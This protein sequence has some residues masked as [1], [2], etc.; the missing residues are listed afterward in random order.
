MK[1]RRCFPIP[2][3]RLPGSLSV[4]YRR[5]GQP[6]RHG[7][8]DKQGHPIGFLTFMAGGKKRVERIP[9]E[10][11][12]EIPRRVDSGLEFKQALAEVFATKAQLLVFCRSLPSSEPE[13]PSY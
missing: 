12:E 8:S 1:G 2:P 7:A 6:T 9:V 4:T 5:S 11:V 10:W 3:H 13:D